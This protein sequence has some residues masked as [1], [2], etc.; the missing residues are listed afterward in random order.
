MTDQPTNKMT[1]AIEASLTKMEQEIG[2]TV[3]PL[4]RTD[5]KMRQAMTSVD[6]KNDNE[7]LSVEAFV[8]QALHC[9][10][11]ATRG[12][13]VTG[14]RDT[15]IRRMVLQAITSITDSNSHAL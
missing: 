14:P 4:V 10:I 5:N 13:Y 9:Q 6:R 2:D 12:K 3:R 11:M 8:D 15:Y 1:D 7:A